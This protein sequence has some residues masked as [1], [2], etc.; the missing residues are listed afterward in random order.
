MVPIFN[1][2]KNKKKRVSQWKILLHVSMTAPSIWKRELEK[3]V[4]MHDGF[5]KPK[6]QEK[7]RE[8]DMKLVPQVRREGATEVTRDMVRVHTIKDSENLQGITTE[9]PGDLLEAFRQRLAQLDL[10]F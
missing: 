3:F 4:V 7:C 2:L 9:Q 10:D 1:E 6:L 8:E 5:R